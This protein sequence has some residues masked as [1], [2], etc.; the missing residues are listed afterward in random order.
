M[1]C[2]RTMAEQ[3]SGDERVDAGLAALALMRRDAEDQGL[4]PVGWKVGFGSPS[5]LALFSLDAPII[6]FLT[7]AG[8]V[9]ATEE[10][11]IADWVAP[12]VECEIAAF[13]ARDIPP[14]TSA[15][16][17]VACVVSWAPAFEFADIDDPPTNVADVL[18][19]NIFHRGYRI[20][21]RFDGTADAV[22][23]LSAEVVLNGERSVVTDVTA[24]TGDLGS[25]IA[26]T[27]ELAPMIG[28]GV[29]A[30]DVILTGSIIPP[31]PVRPGSVITYRL[32]DSPTMA[33]TFT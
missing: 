8:A 3:T 11:D 10:V 32:S 27:A 7:E 17:A 24:L 9:P 25:V 15:S 16:E 13:V 20:G 5:G 6:G 23:A 12:V 18:A 28:R 1:R 21:E 22:S 30:G 2:T 31:A 33:A 26:R 14:G 19:G 4:P 29:Q